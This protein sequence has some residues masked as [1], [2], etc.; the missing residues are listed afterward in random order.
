MNDIFRNIY[1][2]QDNLV[3]GEMSL[4]TNVISMRS[5][6]SYKLEGILNYLSPEIINMEKIDCISDIW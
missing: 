1:L 2:N 6:S 3:I 4:Q 5:S